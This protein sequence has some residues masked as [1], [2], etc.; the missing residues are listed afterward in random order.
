MA[1]KMILRTTQR[2]RIKVL[3]SRVKRFPGR[4]IEGVLSAR[5][6][7]K[8]MPLKELLVLKTSRPGIT[9]RSAHQ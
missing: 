9:P 1:T 8:E 7:P 5:M 6:L 3:F 2:M 4:S